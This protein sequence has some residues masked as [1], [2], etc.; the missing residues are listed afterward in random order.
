MQSPKSVGLQNSKA[1]PFGPSWSQLPRQSQG[2]WLPGSGAQALSHSE[3][4]PIFNQCGC[5]AGWPDCLWKFDLFT[6]RFFTQQKEA[7]Y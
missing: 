7:P 3:N 2:P 5:L 6:L 1:V 4:I